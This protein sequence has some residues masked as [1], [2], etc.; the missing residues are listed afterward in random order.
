VTFSEQLH[1][2]A[3]EHPDQIALICDEQQFSWRAL[4]QDISRRHSDGRRSDVEASLG[5]N[6]ERALWSLAQM[7]AGLPIIGATSGST[8]AAKRYQRSQ[9]SW[10]ASFASD[11]HEFGLTRH[12]V[13]MAPG[14]LTHSLFFYALCHGL[15]RG[16]RV[17]LTDQF[18]PDRVLSQVAR[19]QVTV[20]Y[21]VPTQLKMLIEA[22]AKFAS[23]R[24]RVGTEFPSVRW[25]LS[26]GAKWFQEVTAPLQTMF[27]RATIAEFYGASE[28]SFVSVAKH[29]ADEFLPK[30]SVGKPFHQVRVA[31]LNAAQKPCAPYE[32]GR[33][34]VNSGGLFDRYLGPAPADFSEIFT[35]E[36]GERWCSIGDLGWR[37]QEGYLFLAG[38]ES[39]K[40]ICSGQ[41]ISPEEI[42]QVLH[43]HPLIQSAAV[44]SNADRLRG[45]ALVAVIIP[46]AVAAVLS[47]PELMAFLREHLPEFKI[48]RRYYVI[49]YWPLTAS[50]KTDFAAIAQ[51]VA[52]GSGGAL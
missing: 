15:Y 43:T 47:R 29:G 32:I 12:D 19:H 6:L 16:A 23:I 5:S 9:A 1:R 26:S 17:I 36:G 49:D 42:E 7:Q 20:L 35:N 8:G 10:L 14:A 31:I 4:M 38:R 48:P 27:P 40:I 33:I 45:E 41:N 52:E 3:A 39:R 11:A 44:V 46:V 18:R 21:G 37:D 13:L 30:G 24:G 50:G 51:A 25:V 2:H 28:L 34:F 22:H